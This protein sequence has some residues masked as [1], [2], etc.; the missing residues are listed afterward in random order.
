M[1]Y[2]ILLSIL[3]NIAHAAVWDA[4]PGLH[5][6]PYWEKKYQQWIKEDVEGDFFKK[7]GG[8]YEQLPLD[9]ADAAYG[10]RIYFSFKHKLPWKSAGAKWDRYYSGEFSNQMTEFDHLE[11]PDDK[12][13]ALIEF[14]LDRIGTHSLAETDSFS[15]GFN[16]IKP[17]DVFMYK[18]CKDDSCTR[19]TYIIKDIN[20]DGTF[21]VLYGTQNRAKKKWPLGRTKR[22]YLQHK[23]DYYDWGF[24]RFKTDVDAYTS[25]R[26]ILLN[27]DEQYTVAN[28]LTEDQFF[29]Y[30]NASV[31]VIEETATKKLVRLTESL[32]YALQAR[33][34]VVGDAI[35][36]M[37]EE[38]NRC[39]DEATFDI[40]S[41]PSRDSGIYKQ[42]KKLEQY[43]NSLTPETKVNA[44]MLDLAQGIFQP[45]RTRKNEK[46]QN[47]FCKLNISNGYMSRSINLA[48]FYHKLIDGMVSYHPNDNV[49]WR[50]GIPEGRKSTCHAWYTSELDGG[51]SGN[52]RSRTNTGRGLF[53]LW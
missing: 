53:G 16:D 24:K 14:L 9:C 11:N 10:L 28:R 33:N 25:S 19:H 31:R 39:M 2:F 26:K 51:V 43:V 35:T 27:N 38:G 47:E 36:Y 50:W 7:L 37:E 48:T 20:A 8:A 34:T 42:Y 15:V 13:A 3:I 17:G 12:V 32:C 41:T 6:D 5:W 46:R 29:D 23:P 30:V 40:Y 21:D 1:K 45:N 52:Q 18:Y 4:K 44:W 49:F 22:E